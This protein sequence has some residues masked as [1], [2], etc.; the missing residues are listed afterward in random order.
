MSAPHGNKYNNKLYN[1]PEECQKAYNEYCEWISQGNSAASWCYESDS[2]TITYKTIEKY[3]HEF[4]QD[5]PPSKKETALTKSLA[6]WE[7]RGLSM[8]L[9]QVE[10]CQPAIFQMFMRN[11]FGWD[12]E[13]QSNRESKETLVEKF[14]DKLDKMDA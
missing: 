11:K 8:M 2:L 6:I 1:F 5:F 9:G 7:G 13:S 3:I 12:K 14:L 4:P 10:K